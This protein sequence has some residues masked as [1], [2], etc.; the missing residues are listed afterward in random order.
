MRLNLIPHNKPT[1]SDM[2]AQAALTVIKEGRLMTGETV[3]L[4]E[5]KLGEMH[6]VDPRLVLAAGSGSA[7]LVLSLLGLG[8]EGK[9]V[10][11]PNYCCSSL[12][13]AVYLAGATPVFYDV[14]KGD[15]NW[16]L[17]FRNHFDFLIYPH[18]FGIPSEVPEELS[19]IT[20][21]DCSQA[22]GSKVNSRYVGTQTKISTF[23][24]YATK[25]LT[26]GGQGG[27]V[28]CKDDNVAD[29]L[30][31][32][33]DYDS[34]N[35]SK[36]R[37]NHRMSDLQAAIG[38]VQLERL[39]NE[40][41]PAREQIFL[42]YLDLGLDLIGSS[43]DASIEPVR[44]RTIAKLR[45]RAERDALLDRLCSRGVSAIVPIKDSEILGGK[46]DNSVGARVNAN[47]FLSLPCY[48]SLSSADLEYI[49]E[50]ARMSF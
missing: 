47:L 12:E 8:V 5:E 10:A 20:I 32:Y 19:E 49:C 6:G 44:F 38:I 7:A 43:A 22:I 11:V 15:V 50:T 46:T 45:S 21:E 48:P 37:F 30:R 41:I 23:S 16:M 1:M 34:K 33:L 3:T 4:F 31:D 14:K 36:R 39:M 26:T 29:Y 17:P 27:A 9:K 40:F 2:E 24:F 13:Q 35:D 28:I 42:R 18:L 25:L